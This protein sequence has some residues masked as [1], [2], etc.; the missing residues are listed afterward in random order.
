MFCRLQNTTSI[1]DTRFSI[2]QVEIA[3]KV[4]GA[5]LSPSSSVLVLY[6]PGQDSYLGFR[7]SLFF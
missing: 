3:F 6:E 2:I 5:A 4:S 7:S 1:G